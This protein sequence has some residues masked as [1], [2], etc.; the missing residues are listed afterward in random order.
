MNL[1]L[2]HST[3]N[4]NTWSIQDP[5]LPWQIGDNQNQFTA[6]QQIDELNVVAI[7]D[8]GLILRTFDGGMHWEKQD[9]QTHALL[10]SIH[11]SD[12]LTGIIVSADTTHNI[13][14][15]AD[16]GRHWVSVAFGSLNLWQSYSY[17]AGKFRV[18]KGGNG[19]I[20]TTYDDWQTV[21]SSKPVFDTLNRTRYVLSSLCNFTGGDTILAYG[22]DYSNP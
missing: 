21:D 22:T 13:F 19:P 4:G 14:T 8:S 11:F 17:G 2:W 9:C 7:G 12:S 18:F 10:H 6:V 3:D 1:V 16:G 5:G 15:T 20:Y